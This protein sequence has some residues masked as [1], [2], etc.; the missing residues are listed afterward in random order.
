[1][2][3]PAIPIS[4]RVRSIVVYGMSVPHVWRK[5]MH[6]KLTLNPGCLSFPSMPTTIDRQVRKIERE[7]GFKVAANLRKFT[8]VL[9]LC[10]LFFCI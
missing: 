9:L 8:R 1:M 2:H 6:Y 4:P 7:P 10:M 5:I 3:A